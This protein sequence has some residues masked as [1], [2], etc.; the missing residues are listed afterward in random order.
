MRLV[1]RQLKGMKVTQARDLLAHL[2]KG[3]CLPIS[4]VLHSAVANAT[5]E[6]A[7]KEE[8]LVVARISADEGPMQKRYRSAPMGRAMEI[9]KRT[10]HLTIELDATPSEV[11][12]GA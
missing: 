8:Q 10:S 4:K 11:S 7:W 3:A 12:R 1:A 2:P 5:R 6:G 9:R